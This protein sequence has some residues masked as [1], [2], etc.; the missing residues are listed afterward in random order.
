MAYLRLE[1]HDYHTVSRLC[2]SLELTDYSLPAFKQLLQ[3]CLAE[4]SPALAARVAGLG[5]QRLQLLYR[6]F[7]ERP[8]PRRGHG[9]NGAE[10][11][12]VQAA[13]VPLMAQAR[14]IHL[15][16]RAVVRRLAGAYSDLAAK[17]ERLS[18]GQ[19]AVLCE[20]VQARRRGP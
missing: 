1:P 10:V 3:L 16:K 9:L 2:R 12:A 7:R 17:V 6:H 14:F 19:F 5:R 11:A 8:R 13:G 15:L 20:E 18:L 4:R